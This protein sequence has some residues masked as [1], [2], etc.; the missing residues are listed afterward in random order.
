M[1]LSV[2]VPLSVRLSSGSAFDEGI[3]RGSGRKE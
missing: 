1:D 2:V 3:Q